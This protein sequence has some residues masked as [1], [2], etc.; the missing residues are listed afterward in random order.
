MSALDDAIADARQD[1]GDRTDGQLIRARR[2][3][4]LRALGD[5]RPGRERRARLARDTVKHVLPEWHA[6]RPSDSDPE[7]VLAQIEPVLAGEVDAAEVQRAAG[8]LWAHVDNL[9]ATIGPEAPLHA[10]YAASKALRAA[11]RDEPLDAPDADPD[12]TDFGQDPRMLDTA[13]VAS[14]AAAGGVPWKEAGDP[15]QRRRFW[16]WWLNRAAKAGG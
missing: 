2:H 3:A 14:T 12:R 6:V 5:G 13:F 4:V 9:I 11:L 16:S 1:L 8:L 10:G 15:E 7:R